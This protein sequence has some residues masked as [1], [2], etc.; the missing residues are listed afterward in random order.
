M[1]SEITQTTA[2][3]TTAIRL[4]PGVADAGPESSR[5]GPGEW[6]SGMDGENESRRGRPTPKWKLSRG[7]IAGSSGRAEDPESGGMLIAFY[8]PFDV[9]SQFTPDMP[10]QRTLAEF[11]FARGVY[12]IGRLDRDSEGLLLLSDEPD[13]THRLLDPNQSHPRTYHVQVEGAP[14]ARQFAD[15]Q[16]GV[17]VQGRR[18]RP[19]RA[20]L[21]EPAPTWPPRVPPIRFRKTVPD[22]WIALELTE[23][24]NRQV[25]RMTAAVGLPTLRLIRSQIG[26]LNLADLGLAPGDWRPLNPQETTA[27]LTSKPNPKHAR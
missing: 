22:A 1:A 18:T 7:G 8:K 10:G 26:E 3:I 17:V 12:G 15:L 4:G 11:G 14:T 5:R 21:L 16:A 2:G 19:A 24:R 13:W 23:G 6:V 9:L 27:V 25:R 20:R